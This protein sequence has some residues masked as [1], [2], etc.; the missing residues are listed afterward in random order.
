M[1]D[2]DEIIVLNV[3]F[4]YYTNNYSLNCCCTEQY[5][6]RSQNKCA[7]DGRRR[8][9]RHDGCMKS[10]AGGGFCVAHGGGR[11]CQHDGCMTIT[12]HSSHRTRI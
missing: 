8:L 6:N 9:C 3:V 10:D 7:R 12:L 1:L 5:H 11:R 2:I 4:K